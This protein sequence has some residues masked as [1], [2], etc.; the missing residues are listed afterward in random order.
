MNKSLV[1]KS[2]LKNWVAIFGAPKKVFTDNGGEFDSSIFHELY[3]K[4][5]IKIQT[6]LCY[7]ANVIN[8]KQY[9]SA[10]TYILTS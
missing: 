10:C 1:V 8:N 5:N 6:T 9:Y 7:H 4:F 2:F 3:E